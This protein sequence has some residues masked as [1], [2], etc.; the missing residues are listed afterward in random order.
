MTTKMIKYK[1]S[2]ETGYA[3]AVHRGE[4]EVPEDTTEEELELMLQDEIGNHISAA[5]WADEE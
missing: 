1:W 3:G 4:W 2:I 5:Y